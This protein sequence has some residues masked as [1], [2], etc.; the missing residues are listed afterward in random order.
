MKPQEICDLLV[1]WRCRHRLPIAQLHW[2]RVLTTIRKAYRVAVKRGLIRKGPGKTGSLR[3]HLSIM[4]D[5]N[6][7]PLSTVDID[8]LAIEFCVKRETVN[9]TIRRLKIASAPKQPEIALSKAA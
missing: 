9:R 7:L 6:L 4:G 8:G 5:N 1:R 2:K 3:A